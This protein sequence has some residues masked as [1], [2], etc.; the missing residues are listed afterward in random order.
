MD[1]AVSSPLAEVTWH[2]SR[3]DWAEESDPWVFL[4]LK[5]VFPVFL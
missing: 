2:D 1:D 3:A 5:W 4:V